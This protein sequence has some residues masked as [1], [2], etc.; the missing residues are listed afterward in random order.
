[1]EILVCMKQVPDD[2]VE[3]RLGAPVNRICLRQSPRET[4]LIPMHWS[5][6]S[7]SSKRT[8]APSPW[9]LSEPK[10]TRSA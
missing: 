1:M 2:S 4:L 3:I 9:L 10:T 8:A 7:A 5:W 6:Q